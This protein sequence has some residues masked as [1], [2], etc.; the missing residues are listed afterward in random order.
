MTVKPKV[1]IVCIGNELLSGQVQNTNS[2]FLSKQLTLMGISVSRHTVLGDDLSLLSQGL[3]E[4]FQRADWILCAGGLG[5]TVDDRTKQAIYKILELSEDS[6]PEFFFENTEGIEPGLGFIREGKKMIALPGVPREMEMMF[7]TQVAPFL[8]ESLSV[9]PS[10]YMRSIH[11]CLLSESEIDPLLRDIQAK[12]PELEIGI[13]SSDEKRTIVFTSKEQKYIEVAISLLRKAFYSYE[14]E[15]EEGS[16]SLAIQQILLR[17]GQT[18]AL[19]ESCTGGFM[20][21]LL[22]SQ[23]GSSGYFLGSLVTYSNLLKQKILSVDPIILK[24]QG[25]V[26]AETV[27]QM[28]KGIFQESP[29]DFGIAVSG[30]AGPS[31]GNEGKAVGTVFFALGERKKPAYVGSFRILGGRNSVISLT[32]YRLLS[33]LYRKLNYNV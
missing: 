31:D 6:N 25:A 29:A 22:T 5:A 18:L 28:L 26:S 32:S 12:Y 3:K 15:N 2:F 8:K 24:N 16:L 19:A 1:E 17:K 7:L 10:S 27:E 9:N 20:A 14:I 11:F 33:F 4:C 21:C 13:Y 23:P 30:I